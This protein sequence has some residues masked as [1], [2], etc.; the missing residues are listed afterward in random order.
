MFELPDV[1][2]EIDFYAEE[3]AGDEQLE[4]DDSNIEEDDGK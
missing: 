3:N 2:D 4:E 1:T